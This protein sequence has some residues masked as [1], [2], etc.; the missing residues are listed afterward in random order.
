MSIPRPF[1]KFESDYPD[2]AKAY[3][4]LG[5]AVHASGP[6]DAKTRA[7]IK[8]AVSSGARMEGAVHS[9]TR[10]AQA[11]GATPEEIRQV[12]LLTIPTVGFPNMMASLSW[13]NDILDGPRRDSD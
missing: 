5:D 2:V 6:L 10:K 8:L 11:A 1:L 13:M 3:S 4:E 12:A 7:L 9:H